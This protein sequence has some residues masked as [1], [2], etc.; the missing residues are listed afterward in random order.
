MCNE[1]SVMIAVYVHDVRLYTNRRAY[2][3]KARRSEVGTT[4]FMS[5]AV[6]DMTPCSLEKFALPHRRL[7]QDLSPSTFQ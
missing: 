6:G 4:V 2:G 1:Q 5:T 7:N 3:I